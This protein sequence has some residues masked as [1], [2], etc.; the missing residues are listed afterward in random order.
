MEMC[1]WEPVNRKVLVLHVMVLLNIGNLW[2]LLNEIT[3]FFGVLTYL[4]V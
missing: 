3:S 1:S 4:I 2:L